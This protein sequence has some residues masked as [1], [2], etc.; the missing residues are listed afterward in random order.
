LRSSSREGNPASETRVKAPGRTVQKKKMLENPGEPPGVPQLNLGKGQ[1]EK[2]TGWGVNA[3]PT[4]ETIERRKVER[5]TGREGKKIESIHEAVP[6]KAGESLS[7]PNKPKKKRPTSPR[8]RS[9]SPY[10]PKAPIKPRGV[11]SAASKNQKEKNSYRPTIRK[12]KQETGGRSSLFP[13]VGVV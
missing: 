13:P 7:E 9:P 6:C 10:Q 5:Q 8:D 2:R 3:A 12:R 4:N 1:E 11:P